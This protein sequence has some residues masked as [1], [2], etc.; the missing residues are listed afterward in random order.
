MTFIGLPEYAITVTKIIFKNNKN[1]R[2]NYFEIDVNA[3][4]DANGKGLC[5]ND[6]CP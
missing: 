6:D 2:D 1:N 3:P 4:Y 5:Y